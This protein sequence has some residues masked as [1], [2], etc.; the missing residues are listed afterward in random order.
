[1]IRRL[2]A[3]GCAL[4][5]AT[6][7]SAAPTKPA[8]PGPADWR[9]PDPENL[10]VLETSKG[11]IIVEMVPQLAPAHVARVR[12]LTRAG[13]YDGRKFFRVIDGFMAQTGDPQDTGEGGSDKPDLGSEFSFRRGMESGMVVAAAQ[14]GSEVGFL[15]PVPVASQN[16]MMMSLTADGRVTAWGLFCPGVAGMARAGDPNSANSQFFLMRSAYPSLDKRYTP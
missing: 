13:L 10:L 14:G 7:A 12:E 4:A 1:M 15:G 16:S 2:L 6:T 5:L 11:R 8:A 9:T 3:V